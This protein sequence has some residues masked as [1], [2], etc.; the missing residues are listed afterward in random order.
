MGVKPEDFNFK[1]G[2]FGHQPLDPE[3]TRLLL[4]DRKTGKLEHLMMP[5]MPDVVKGHEVWGNDSIG[6]HPYFKQQSYYGCKK[7]SYL[8][9]TAG[10]A[11]SPSIVSRMDFHLLTLHTH[12][13][14]KQEDVWDCYRLDVT[15]REPYWLY[16]A[17]GTAPVAV[18]TTVAKALESWSLLG[19]L[20]GSSG[21]FV[22]PGWQWRSVGMF[23]TNFHG[24]KEPLLAMTCAF[25]G[26]D[27]IREAH[28]VAF[29]E[30]YAFS[31]YGD[32]MLII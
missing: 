10:V 5:D 9:P 28:E 22:R 27:L 21:I 13:P 17:P 14:S 25:G 30:G 23:M 3:K 8:P 16:K 26:T 1:M 12:C 15:P 4:I 18:G 2:R 24:P 32:R 11:L 19:D 20:S 7:G 6:S 31:D 29:R